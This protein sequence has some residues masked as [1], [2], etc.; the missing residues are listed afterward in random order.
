MQG[1]CISESNNRPP[2]DPNR[3]PLRG[4]YVV[5]LDEDGE[6]EN[7]GKVLGVDGGKVLVRIFHPYELGITRVAHYA[8]TF[9]YSDSVELYADVESF[10]YAV[11]RYERRHRV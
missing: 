10:E 9:I 7:R 4:L 1:K 2:S 5:I 6:L 11:E 8:R 3:S